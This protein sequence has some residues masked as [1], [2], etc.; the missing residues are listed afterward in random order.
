MIKVYF[1]LHP[2]LHWKSETSQMETWKWIFLGQI[3]LNQQ[4]HTFYDWINKTVR[5]PKKIV[6]K[7]FASHSF[8]VFQHKHF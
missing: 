2:A 3:T 1:T 5:L 8:V 6:R 7:N 4:V